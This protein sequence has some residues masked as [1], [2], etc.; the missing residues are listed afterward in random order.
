MDFPTKKIIDLIDQ[1]QLGYL[2]FSPGLHDHEFIIH[3]TQAQ[4]LIRANQI[5]ISIYHLDCKKNIVK[6]LGFD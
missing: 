4:D 1:R 5:L 2:E 6:Q 3:L